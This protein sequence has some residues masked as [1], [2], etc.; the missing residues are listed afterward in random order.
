[1]IYIG[2]AR[3][4]ENGKITGGAAGDQKQTSNT[5][6]TKGEVSIQ[7][8]Y[9]HKKDWNVLRPKSTTYAGLIASKM[10][11]ACNN[12]NIGY[13][14]SDRLGV[15]KYGI[16]TKTPTNADCSSLV[17]ECIK[18]ATGTD[19]GNFTTADEAAKLKATGLFEEAF[20][21]I[22]QDKTPVYN[23]D[24]LVT[25][26]KGHTA[27]VVSGNPRT[28]TASKTAYYAKY[29]GA[30]TSLVEA[31]SSLG[32]KDTTREHRAKIAKAN[33]MSEYSGTAAQ[34]A[35]LLSLLK[36]GKLIKA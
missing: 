8:M 19:P 30:S 11:S 4:G 31:L 13:N 33:G 27:I 28:S 12:K 16:S 2:S 23:G 25:C 35:K 26:T 22:S 6:D 29:T 7:P 14:Q 24:I 32:V 20:K 18:E 5:N 17:R 36:K 21:Y 1:M 10:T 9:T 3:L 34:N 15:I